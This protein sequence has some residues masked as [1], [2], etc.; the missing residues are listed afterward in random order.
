MMPQDDGRG[1]SAPRDGPGRF[2]SQYLRANVGPSERYVVSPPGKV[3]VRPDARAAAA[4]VS[5]RFV[6]GGWPVAV[7]RTP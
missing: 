2:D 7:P 3:K 1:A 4:G 6:A 5:H